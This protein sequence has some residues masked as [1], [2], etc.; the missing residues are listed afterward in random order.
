MA[1]ENLGGRIMGA[2]KALRHVFEETVSA[3]PVEQWIQKA[4]TKRKK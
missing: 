2:K 3:S 4:F 1:D